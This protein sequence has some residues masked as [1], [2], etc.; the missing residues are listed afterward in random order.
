MIDIRTNSDTPT[1]DPTPPHIHSIHQ[2]LIQQNIITHPE[3]ITCS[4]Q[5]IKKEEKDIPNPSKSQRW[6][7]AIM[8]I[9]APSAIISGNNK[10]MC[11]WLLIVRYCWITEEETFYWHSHSDTL[12]PIVWWLSKKSWVNQSR[13]S[14]NHDPTLN[15]YSH[16]NIVFTLWRNMKSVGVK[17]LD[18][19]HIATYKSAQRI[20]CHQMKF[21]PSYQRNGEELFQRWVLT[22]ISSHHMQRELMCLRIH[23]VNTPKIKILMD[24]MP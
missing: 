10:S 7:D 9:T 23:L 8:W 17:S 15:S 13:N 19:P 21:K 5:W 16:L 24:W 14:K 3:I 11:R 20:Q 2:S 22:R 12:N 4:Q 1:S 6:R 18:M